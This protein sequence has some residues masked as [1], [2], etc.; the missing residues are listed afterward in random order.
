MLLNIPTD[1]RAEILDNYLGNVRK[2]FV[3]LGNHKRNAYEDV[4]SVSQADDAVR[5]E[6]SRQG[7]YD[8]LPEALFHPIDRFD[9]IPPNEYKERFSEEVEQQRIEESNARSFF[10]IYDKFIFDLSS[11]VSAIKNEDL[12]DNCVLTDIICDSLPDEYRSNRFVA[13]TKEFLPRCRSIRGNSALITLILRK[14][15]YDEGLKLVCSDTPATFE[16]ESPRYNCRLREDGSS[17]EL[18]LGN[19]YEENVMH[20]D[21]QYWN[22]DSCN[23]S[24]LEFVDEI[25]VFESFVNDYFMGIEMSVRFNISTHTVPVRL[26][27]ELCYNYLNY[28]TNI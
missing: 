23:E 9:N 21:V 25:N 12:T 16:D 14:V 11:V 26:S 6:L 20:Y 3:F 18:Y 22:D 5:I 2:E 24:F 15:M 1:I 28:N 10:S 27:D 17:G 19:Q 7:L 4:L 13:R 8:I